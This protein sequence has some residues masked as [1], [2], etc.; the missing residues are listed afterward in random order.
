MYNSFTI[1]N[2]RCFRDLT[3]EP[4]ERVNLITGKN[5]VG[6]TALL[7]ALFL[8]L[9]PSNP[10]LALQVNTVRGVEQ[11]AGDAEE[12]WEWLFFTRKVQETIELTGLDED[13]TTRRLSIRLVESER[14]QLSPVTDTLTTTSGLRDLLLE[15]RDAR[16]QISTTRVRADGATI[17]RRGNGAP[18][19]VGVYLSTRARTFKEDAARFSNLERVGRHEGLLPTLNLL[20][21]RLRRL[22]VLVTGGVPIINGDIGIGELIPL[23]LMG[24]GM[25][26]LLSI[27]LAI[28]NAPGGVVLVDEIENGLHHAVMTGVWEAIAN[29]A[30]KS[31]TQV[32]ATTHSWE[33]VQGAHQAFEASGTYDFRLHR[34]DRV[35]DDIQAVAYDRETLATSAEMNLEVR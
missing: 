25:V 32:F 4:L 30:R 1:K 18:L 24:E 23:P 7:E 9:G 6:K 15:H 33:C 12:M 19:P 17:T 16:G 10:S 27:L 3:L 13:N 14:A 2:F 21:P 26:R 29:L 8:H 22:A 35:G 31:Q 5:N 28:A 20:E 11:R 34:L